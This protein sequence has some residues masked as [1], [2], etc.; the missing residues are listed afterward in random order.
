MAVRGGRGRVHVAGGSGV[1]H[2]P[3]YDRRRRVCDDDDDDD[4]VCT[5]G[6]YRNDPVRSLYESMFAHNS[7]GVE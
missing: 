5:Q 4:V 1:S 7:R 6:G 3:H 2:S